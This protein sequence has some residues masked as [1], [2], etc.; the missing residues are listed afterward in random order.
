[1]ESVLHKM[2]RDEPMMRWYFSK[3]PKEIREDDLQKSGGKVFQAAGTTN[4]KR[5]RW[6]IAWQ[7]GEK[8]ARI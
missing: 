3:N 8:S 7:A 6:E 5:L 1:M 2:V 4:L